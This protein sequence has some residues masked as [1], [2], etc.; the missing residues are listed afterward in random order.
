MVQK[1][2]QPVKT[3]LVTFVDSA[4]SAIAGTAASNHVFSASDG[5][6]DVSIADFFKRPVRISNQVWSLSETTGLKSTTAPFQLWAANAYVKNKLNNYA[7]FRGD[8]KVKIQIT[9]SPFLFGALKAIW[10]P[11]TAYNPSTILP[12]SFKEAVPLS[13]RPH[14]TIV[15][16]ENSSYEMMLPFIFP[17]NWLDCAVS[18]DFADLGNLDYYIWTQLQSANGAATGSISVVTYCWV[19]NLELSGATVAYAAQSDEYGDGAISAPASAIANAAG[20]LSDLPIIGPLATATQIGA[21]AVSKIAR[22]FGFSN[23]PVIDDTSPVI[24]EQFPKLSSTSISYPV[25][26]LTIDPK[27]ELSIDPRIVGLANGEDEMSIK[28][29]ASRESYLTSATWASSDAVDTLLFQSRINPYQYE[30]FAATAPAASIMYYTPMAYVANCFSQWRGTMIFRFHI[31]ASKY[32]KGRLLINFDPTGTTGTNIGNTASTSGV[33]HT[34]IVDIGETTD[35]E[36]H[37]PY[38]QG[39]QFLSVR[40]D[41][42]AAGRNWSTLTTNSYNYDPFYDNGF[43]TIRVLNQLTS[44]TASTSIKV[45]VYVKAGDDIEFANPTETDKTNRLSLFSSQSEILTETIVADPMILAETKTATD[46]QY[47]VHMGERIVSMRQLMRRYN[48]LT[49]ESIIPASSTVGNTNVLV[50]KVFR[51]P[52]SPGYANGGQLSANGVIIPLT[53]YPYN[54]CNMTLMSYFLPAFM[55]QR[56]S[57]NYTFNFAGKLELN[58]IRAYRDNQQI[59]PNTNFTTVSSNANSV[60]KFAAAIVNKPSGASGSAII[61]NA[62]QSGLNVSLPNYS[63]YK[64]ASTNKNR[65]NTGSAADG[66]IYDSLIIEADFQTDIT[67]ADKQ[68]LYTYV[69]A[70]T[71]YAMHYFLNVPSFWVY[72]AVPAAP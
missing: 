67:T 25:Q 7:W 16:G 53:T 13:Q 6:T 43:L 61:N 57:V 68:F 18:Q 14:V 51:N 50:K 69:A 33:V 72:S 54:W 70:G 32:H 36:F 3:G 21:Q 48:L 29:I 59:Y 8:L 2:T 37:V 71:D 45:L 24:N 27:N 52:L 47:L 1:S 65:C 28:S 17:K 66:S 15:P 4:V 42:T 56:G 39:T 12:S 31:I 64:F 5:N 26:K 46:D 49:Q 63:N 22:I 30:V 10:Q 55:C 41:V 23:P 19:E 40:D 20:L 62:T 35:V 9:A 58:H 34:S 44:P 38:Q 60:N 11:L